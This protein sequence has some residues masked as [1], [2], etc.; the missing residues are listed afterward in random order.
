LFPFFFLTLQTVNQT[1]YQRN[2]EIIG[3]SH[4]IVSGSTDENDR[5]QQAGA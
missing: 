5:S 1:I 2:E 4:H 3:D